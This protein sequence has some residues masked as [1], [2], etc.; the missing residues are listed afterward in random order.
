MEW[1]DPCWLP[2]RT[3]EF[4]RSLPDC[5]ISELVSL[6][7]LLCCQ[8][9]TA[10]FV[11]ELHPR[12][13]FFLLNGRIKLSMNSLEGRRLILGIVGSGEIVGLA[14]AVSGKP[15]DM[16]AET[17]LPCVIASIP[18]QSLLDFLNRYPIALHNVARLL[19]LENKRYCEQLRTVG[20]AWTAAAR[21]ARLLL[22][23]SDEGRPTERGIRFLCPLTHEEIAEH[24]GVSRETVTRTLH[25]FRSRKLVEQRG[26][27]LFVSNRR[28][29][30]IHARVSFPDPSR[31]LTPAALLHPESWFSALPRIPA[32]VPSACERP[33]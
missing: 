27:A 23:W 2:L 12:T 7:T 28:G 3:A 26:A 29:L 11:E 33:G 6:T 21:L 18:R 1:D 17:Q 4:F 30:E 16:T 20:L 31:C 25:G 8:T 15:Y 5:A 14:S 22:E 9:N 19:S 24:I 13:V 10:L 32:T